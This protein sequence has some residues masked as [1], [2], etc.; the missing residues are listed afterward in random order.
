M[1]LQ[2]QIHF[3]NTN[4][5]PYGQ[6]ILLSVWRYMYISDIDTDAQGR[7][8]YIPVSSMDLAQHI[9]KVQYTQKPSVKV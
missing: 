3:L 8:D 2:Q 1:L 5:V 6:K 9:P 4:C 7:P